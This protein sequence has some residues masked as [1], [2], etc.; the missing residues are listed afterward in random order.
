MPTLGFAQ[1]PVVGQVAGYG[2]LI[3]IRESAG[4]ALGEAYAAGGIEAANT[5]AQ[6]LVE[7]DECV[8]IGT[9]VPGQQNLVLP[10]ETTR[11]IDSYVFAERPDRSATLVQGQVQDAKPALTVYAVFLGEGA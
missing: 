1:V 4:R 3:C 11:I 10:I 6:A 5:M 2:G 8:N 9:L 7:R